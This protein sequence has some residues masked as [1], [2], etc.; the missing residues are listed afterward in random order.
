MPGPR[1]RGDYQ[2]SPSQQRCAVVRALFRLRGSL[3]GSQ[4]SAPSGEHPPPTPRPGGASSLR[5]GHPLSRP[6]PA[7]R[8]ACRRGLRKK[9]VQ[10]SRQ[11]RL[12]LPSPPHHAPAALGLPRLRRSLSILLVTLRRRVELNVNH[13]VPSDAR[14][15]QHDR[16][17]KPRALRSRNLYRKPGK[18]HRNQHSTQPSCVRCLA[19]VP[20]AGTCLHRGTLAY[21]LEDILG[22]ARQLRSETDAS[23]NS[24]RSPNTCG[25][26]EPPQ[27][28]LNS[29]QR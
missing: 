22:P 15:R 24:T 19:C 27:H 29:P 26:Q 8:K 9:S 10:R 4:R 13:S 2:P 20:I 3:P 6:D 28:L 23:M 1:S 18:W 5:H 21:T 11:C 7:R 12:G 14:H 25:A 16:H 17:Q